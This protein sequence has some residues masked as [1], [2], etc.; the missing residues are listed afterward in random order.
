MSTISP[1]DHTKIGSLQGSFNRLQ[2]DFDRA[3][4]VAVLTVVRRSGKQRSFFGS[5]YLTDTRTCY[6]RGIEPAQAVE[7]GRSSK[8]PGENVLYGRNAYDSAR[9]YRLL[10]DK[11]LRQQGEI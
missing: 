11:P 3:V 2:E 4:D 1:K 6:D 8:L 10:G 9:R 5:I 7:A